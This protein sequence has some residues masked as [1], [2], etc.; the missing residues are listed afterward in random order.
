[1]KALFIVFNQAYNE[2]ITDILAG[3]GQKGFTRWN[4][5]SGR[6]SVTG[7]PRFGNHAWPEMN[8]AVLSIID[9]D[10]VKAVLDEVKAKDEQTPELGLRAFVWNIE[11]FY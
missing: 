8:N 10:K 4:E 9:D 5:V 2:E 6:G 11:T 3:L 7:I 1:M